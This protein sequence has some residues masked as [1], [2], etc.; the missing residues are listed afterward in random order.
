MFFLLST[1]FLLPRDPFDRD[2]DTT[3]D[4]LEWAPFPF[5]DLVVEDVLGI[6]DILDPL[7]ALDALDPLDSLDDLLELI[8]GTGSGRLR[9]LVLDSLSEDCPSLL[10]LVSGLYLLAVLAY[11]APVKPS[12]S[13]EM[14][15]RSSRA[16]LL[17]SRYCFL[18][19]PESNSSS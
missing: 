19:L 6:D 3:L 7:D 17:A 2:G 18:C 10:L 11:S 14:S 16:L 8:A 15:E 13:S 12:S 1:S 9:V 4:L 5:P